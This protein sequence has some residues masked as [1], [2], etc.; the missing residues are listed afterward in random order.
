MHDFL[1]DIIIFM[2]KKMLSGLRVRVQHVLGYRSDMDRLLD[3]Y[4]KA[5]SKFTL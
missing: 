5:W 2:N 4:L 3:T 1:G